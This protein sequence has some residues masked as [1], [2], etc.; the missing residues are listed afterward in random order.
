MSNGNSVFIKKEEAD[1]DRQDMPRQWFKSAADR[2]FV[3]RYLSEDR[4]QYSEGAAGDGAR[5]SV[6]AVAA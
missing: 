2:R 1:A 6:F 3:R 4:T 5:V